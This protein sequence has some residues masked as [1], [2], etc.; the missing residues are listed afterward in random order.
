MK[1][2][3][4]SALAVA[5][6]AGAALPAAAQAWDPGPVRA[7]YGDRGSWDYDRADRL[8]WRID[9]GERDGSLNRWEARRLRSE[10]ND[11]RSLQYRYMRDGWMNGWR[12]ADLDRRY[13]ALSQRIRWE[14][15]DGDYRPGPY[16]R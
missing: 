1:K 13:E 3:L 9:R 10:L 16:Y 15:R 4:L 2:I 6:V 14:K 5:A 11:I 8:A 7:D 12:R